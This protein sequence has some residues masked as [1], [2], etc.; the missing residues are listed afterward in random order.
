M[1]VVVSALGALAVSV[2]H[3]IFKKAQNTVTESN[4]YTLITDRLTK[5]EQDYSNLESDIEKYRDAN[6]A[7]LDSIIKNQNQISMDIASIKGYLQGIK[8]NNHS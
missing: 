1:T 4:N 2:Y 6:T 3:F 7:K 8:E 5:L